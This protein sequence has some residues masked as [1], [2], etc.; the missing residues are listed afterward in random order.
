MAPAAALV[1]LAL[2][3][4]VALGRLAIVKTTAQRKQ[5]SARRNY[6]V[7]FPRDLDFE[8]V[9]HFVRSLSG[10]PRNSFFGPLPTVVFETEADERGIRHHLGVPIGLADFVLQQ[11]R[12]QVPGV[13][14]TP[15]HAQIR[16]LARPDWTVAE[17]LALTDSHLPLRISSPV[18]VTSTLLASFHP[19]KPGQALLLQWVVGANRPAELPRRET[20]KTRWPFGPLYASADVVKAKRDKLSDHTFVA[21]GRVAAKAESKIEAERLARR[22][23]NGLSSTRSHGVAW[24]RRLVPRQTLLDRLERGAAPLSFSMMLSATELATLIAYPVGGASVPGLPQ[25]RSRH[26]AADNAIPTEGIVVGVSNF[27]GAERPLAISPADLTKHLHLIG[28]TGTGKSSLITN[29]VT[30]Q[31]AAGYGAAVLDP[32]GDLVADI[33]DRIPDHRTADVVVLDPT[34]LTDPVGFNILAGSDPLLVTDQIMNIFHNVYRDSWG[35]R[36]AD[37]LRTSVLTLTQTPGMTLVE[38]PA[39]LTDEAFRS[40]VVRQV[41]DRVLKDYWRIYES[42]SS[43]ERN[44][45][46][47]P[48]MNKLRPLLLDP[49]IRATLGQSQSGFDM[50]QILS[51]NKILLVALAKGQLGEETASLFGSL[52]IAKLWQAAQGRSAIPARDRRPFFTHVDEFQ[53]FLNLPMSVADVLAQARGYGFSLT[54]AHQHLSQLPPSLRSAVLAN[55]RSRIV[56]Q[57]AADDAKTLA[58][59]F[60]GHVEPQ[61]L[62]GLAQ[63]E[64]VVQLVAGDQVAPPATLRTLPPGRRTGHA[65]SVRK[66]SRA[67]YGRPLAEVEAEFLARHKSLSE[68]PKRPMVGRVDES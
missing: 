65:R 14:V 10:L 54:L 64:A 21:V 51:G 53:D 38:I 61:D 57:T 8:A 48:V 59:E 26:L 34:D 1:I 25:G 33:L 42:Q 63:Y 28:P 4:A 5:D 49:R 20:V 43:G 11:L 32:K 47:A 31:I 22:V 24:R 41:K 56:F 2:A 58:H 36:M 16:A 67:V 30:A 39:L 55:A 44:Q 66:A 6:L 62:Q 45:A 18:A 9:L 15:E 35:P 13:H 17:E 37:V 3:G 27:P 29:L 68:P 50:P 52:V 7:T 40:S 60:S 12:S 23:F 46:I 19:L